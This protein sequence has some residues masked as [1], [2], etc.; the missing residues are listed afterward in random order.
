MI[1]SGE[2]IMEM[3]MK[4]DGKEVEVFE[5]FSLIASEVISTKSFASNCLEAKNIFPGTG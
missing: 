4:Y 3:W 2:T 5:H 1:K